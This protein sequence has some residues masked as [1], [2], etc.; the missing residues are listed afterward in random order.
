MA[1]TEPLH[2]HLAAARDMPNPEGISKRL[3][4]ELCEAGLDAD[5]YAQGVLEILK[6]HH[7]SVLLA[8]DSAVL[9][10]LTDR[11]DLLIASL[12]RGK[13]TLKKLDS[14]AVMP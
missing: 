5:R 13:A 11:L 10:L 6:C 1:A 12:E 7:P 9:G 3:H 14:L 2:D 8:G 4:H